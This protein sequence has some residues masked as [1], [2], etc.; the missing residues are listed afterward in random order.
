MSRLLAFALLVTAAFDWWAPFLDRAGV[1]LLGLAFLAL[2]VS[3]GGFRVARP[4][5]MTLPPKRVAL[6]EPAG[7]EI[8]DLLARISGYGGMSNSANE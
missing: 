5:R 3:P 8:D 2:T 4:A 7:D 6:P 1:A